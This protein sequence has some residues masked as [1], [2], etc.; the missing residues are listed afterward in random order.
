[1]PRRGYGCFAYANDPFPF[2]SIDA[3]TN[4]KEFLETRLEQIKSELKVLEESE[5]LE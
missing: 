4:S 5:K 2:A 1:M 3:F